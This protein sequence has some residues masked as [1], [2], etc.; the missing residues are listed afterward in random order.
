MT[1]CPTGQTNTP[2]SHPQLTICG[3]FGPGGGEEVRGES[4]AAGV[5]A[6]V[7]GAGVGA[8]FSGG[9]RAGVGADDCMDDSCAARSGVD[10]ACCMVVLAA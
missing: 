5:S 1:G 8:S 4:C 3:G 6:A 2:L 10:A 9:R 7:V